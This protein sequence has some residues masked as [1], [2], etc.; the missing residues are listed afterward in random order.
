MSIKLRKK[1][2]M[3]GCPEDAERY[4]ECVKQGIKDFNSDFGKKYN[5]E[6]EPTHYKSDMYSTQDNPQKAINEQL[7]NSCD[8]LIAIFYLSAGTAEATPKTGTFEEID[9][10]KNKNRNAFVFCFSGNVNV[11]LG[12]E[13]KREQLKNLLNVLKENQKS[14]L[15]ENYK[16]ENELAQKVKRNLKNFFELNNPQK[17]SPRIKNNKAVKIHNRNELQL[18][19]ECCMRQNDSWNWMAPQ[20]SFYSKSMK[21]I[22]GIREDGSVQYYVGK[23]ERYRT[24]PVA[25]V[26][27]ALYLGA[28]IP[29]SVCRKM[30]DWV[31]KSKEDPCDEPNK[32]KTE[33]TGHK[34]DDCDQFGWS[35]NEGVSVW[36]TSKALN[37]LIMT[38]YYKREDICN[39]SEIHGVTCKALNWLADQA[40]DNGGWG[41]QK[42]E[43]L[44]DCA[45]SVT[46]TALTLTTI[47]R[48]LLATDER[49][50][51]TLDDDLEN[52]LSE[53]RK[54]GI[55]YLLNTKKEKDN[56]VYWEYNGFPSLTGTVWVLDFINVGKRRETGDLYPLKDKILNFCLE[57]IPSTDDELERY[58][59]EV[60]FTGG[61]TKYKKIEKNNKFYSYMPYHIAVLLQAG[62][63]PD[64][65]HI[66][67][68]IMGLISG[69]EDYWIGTD[70]SAGAHQRASCFVIAMALSVI[71]V[72]MKR[73]IK[74]RIKRK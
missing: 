71:A 49:N 9:Y 73:K 35:W 53:A 58:Q 36:A 60:Y 11:D 43:D 61:K 14:I 67:T 15:F 6:L 47:T 5:V 8:L 55:D 50:G 34:P 74:K 57:N 69:K 7:C 27:E 56:K 23:K 51:I 42:A 13:Q 40:Y 70:R 20:F 45:A 38:D 68:C 63:D 32:L 1:K 12:N 59:E 28:L 30:Q 17:N 52:K 21:L 37:T 64:D 25:S 29:E 62:A 39:N 54:K 44:V 4:I 2:V 66:M 19:M 41:F 48:F 3:I 16:N 26:L 46:M 72:W 24:T 18:Q 31:Y 65:K 33:E 22:D 10:F